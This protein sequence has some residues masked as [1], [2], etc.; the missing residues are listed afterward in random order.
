[1][2][3]QSRMSVFAGF[4]ASKWVC[5]CER[6]E[7][8]NAVVWTYHGIDLFLSAN[9]LNT[10]NV[11]V[12]IQDSIDGT[13]WT[14]RW[15]ST[16]AIVPGGEQSIAAYFSGTHVRVLVYSTGT[17]RIDGTVNVPEEQG[18]AALDVSNPT[19]QTYCEVAAES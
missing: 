7:P 3:K 11:E 13:T 19:C 8:A 6:V 9:H 2:S 5:L 15:I 1:M 18:L 17:G 10:A 12:A 4:A 14:T 16:A